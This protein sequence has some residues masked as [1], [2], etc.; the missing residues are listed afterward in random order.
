M[1]MFFMQC[2][3]CIVGYLKHI[4]NSNIFNRSQEIL[5]FA[6]FDDKR[7]SYL[8]LILLGLLKTRWT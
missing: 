8:N 4:Q 6:L 5:F 2:V 1:K 7:L 3:V